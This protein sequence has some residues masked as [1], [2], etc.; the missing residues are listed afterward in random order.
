MMRRLP[1]FRLCCGT[2]V[3][4]RELHGER[5]RNA[6]S[7]RERQ[8]NLALSRSYPAATRPFSRLIN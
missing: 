8:R 1:L 6:G 2:V 7:T 5:R 3:L 4:V